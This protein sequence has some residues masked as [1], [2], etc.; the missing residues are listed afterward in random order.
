[1]KYAYSCISVWIPEYYTYTQI[2]WGTESKGKH[3]MT[4]KWFLK[5]NI[6]KFHNSTNDDRKSGSFSFKNISSS[7]IFSF[8]FILSYVL[9]GF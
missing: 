9:K 4:V 1:M 8:V 7:G 6:D 3:G 2:S 5:F